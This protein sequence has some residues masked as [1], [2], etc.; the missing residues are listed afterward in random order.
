MPF[1]T[2]HKNTMHQNYALYELSFTTC[3][4]RYKGLVEAQAHA[5]YLHSTGVAGE[6]KHGSGDGSNTNTL[7]EED[8][9]I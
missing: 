1:N 9:T 4:T 3:Q 5:H 7:S 6:G 2:L 8:K